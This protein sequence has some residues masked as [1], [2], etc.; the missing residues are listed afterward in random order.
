M[1]KFLFHFNKK[2][3]FFKFST[4]FINKKK[5]TI[6]YKII[7]LKRV[8]YESGLLEKIHKYIRKNNIWA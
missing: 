2:K 1:N 7:K 4:K 6:K 8:I 3:I 5:K